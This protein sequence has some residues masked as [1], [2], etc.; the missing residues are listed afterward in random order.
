MNISLILG[1]ATAAAVLVATILV[2]IFVCT[3]RKRKSCSA[4]LKNRS[5]KSI[6]SPL[7]IPGNFITDCYICIKFMHVTIDETSPLLPPSNHDG[8]DND[9]QECSPVPGSKLIAISIVFCHFLYH[10]HL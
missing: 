9:I 1:I 2:V 6:I 8:S 5:A 3:I 7:R 10:S 4:R